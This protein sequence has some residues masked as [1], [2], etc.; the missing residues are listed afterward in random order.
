MEA[1]G[2]L[3]VPE[4]ADVLKLSKS[5]VYAL[6]ERGEMPVVRIGKSVRILASDLVAWINSRREGGK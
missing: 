1:M 6:I 3:T 4:V 2:I 5:K